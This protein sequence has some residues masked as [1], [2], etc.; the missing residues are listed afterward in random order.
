MKWIG[1]ALIAASLLLPP[2]FAGDFYINLASQILIAGIFALSLNLLVGFGGMTSLGHA[3]YLGVAAYISALLTSRYGL[4]HGPAAIVS[5]AGTTA[6]AAVFGIIALRAS[7]LGF[8]MNNEMDDFAAKP[9]EENL[10]HLIQGEANAIQPGK[11]PLS[12]MTPTILVRDGKPFLVLGAPGGSRITTTVLEII[13]NLIDHGMTLQEAVDAPR[14]HHQWIPDTLAGEPFVGRLQAL[15]RAQPDLH[16]VQQRL[17]CKGLRQIVIRAGIKAL[18]PLLDERLG[19]Y[20]H[21][22]SSNSPSTQF[23]ATCNSASTVSSCPRGSTSS[24]RRWRRVLLI[25]CR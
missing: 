7:G 22:R 13:F 25:R 21:Q 24:A 10:F 6:M 15:A 16:A 23:T 1:V 17:D 11:R 5:I 20:D 9:G 12:S 3:S 8:L 18:Y 4:G 19:R 14:I 2:L